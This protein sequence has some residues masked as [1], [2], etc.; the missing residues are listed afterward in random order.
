M[1]VAIMAALSI[2]NCTALPNY[3]VLNLM[4]QQLLQLGSNS[5]EQHHQAGADAEEMNSSV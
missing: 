4:L 2:C 3:A 5:S 1:A